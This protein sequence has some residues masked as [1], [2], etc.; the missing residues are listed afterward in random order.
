MKVE[1][2]IEMI[3]QHQEQRVTMPPTTTFVTEID[4]IFNSFYPKCQY[5]QGTYCKIIDDVATP[6]NCGESYRYCNSYKPVKANL[7]VLRN[8][9]QAIK[10]IRNELQKIPFTLEI[11]WD[12]EEEVRKWKENEK[13]RAA[14]EE[15]LE[16]LNEISE[17]IEE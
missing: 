14:L 10:Q 1:E 13:K 11:D 17:K 4:K 2:I 12:N 9:K 6:C 5:L 3:L 7:T 15:K 8:L 16:E